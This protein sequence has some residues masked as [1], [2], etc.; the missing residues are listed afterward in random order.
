M[1]VDLANKVLIFSPQAF[2]IFCGLG[3]HNC[4]MYE[5][6][7]K[8]MA[9]QKVALEVLSFHAS[10]Q[11]E[12]IGK[13]VVRLAFIISGIYQIMHF[14]SWSHLSLCTKSAV[15]FSHKKIIFDYVTILQ[16]ITLNRKGEG[17]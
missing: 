6:A 13:F 15:F 3:I 14:F 9:K 8:L 12:N 4:T 17:G 10:A 5:N 2:S 16:T 7:C 1:L 11:N